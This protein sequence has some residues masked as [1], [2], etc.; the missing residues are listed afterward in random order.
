MLNVIIIKYY[1]KLDKVALKLNILLD[2][3]CEAN[4]D[5][6][7][8]QNIINNF[9]DISTEFSQ[10]IKELKEKPKDKGLK[11]KIINCINFSSKIQFTEDIT[12]GNEIFKKEVLN[13][14]LEIIFF[15]KNIGT[16]TA[17]PNIDTKES[18]KM[19]N[20]QK[21]PIKFEIEAFYESQ[22][23]NKI[24][25]KIKIKWKN[26]NLNANNIS[27][28]IIPKSIFDNDDFSN[29]LEEEDDYIYYQ[30]SDLNIRKEELNYDYNL[31]R[32]LEEYR[33][34]LKDDVLL[35]IKEIRDDLLS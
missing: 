7:S 35:K 21:L 34:G 10:M 5:I 4:D 2:L 8:N 26:E 9:A 24:E 30:S 17:H 14:I 19:M 27:N 31:C 12:I 28:D 22:L 11:D 23:K 6:I 15:I 20:I 13:Y 3:F 16:K 25:D 29:S 18:L 32:N 33:K 1:N